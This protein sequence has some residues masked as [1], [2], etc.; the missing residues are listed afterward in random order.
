MLFRSAIPE[1]LT[2]AMTIVLSIA[3]SKMAKKK[4]IVKKLNAV[5]SLGSCS[6]IATDKT[7]T[8]TCNEQTAKKIILPTGD[9]AYIKGV[10]YNDLGEVEFDENM[11]NSSKEEIKEIAKLG[12]LNNEATLKFEDGKW[13][14][15][16]DAIDRA[17]LALAYKLQLKKEEEILETIPYES[18]D[19]KSV[20]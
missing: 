9:S 15:H 10:G 3:S 6:V 20:V 17:F 19:R 8:L 4:V 7:G 18:K 16:G 14:H 2:I 13:V 1:G 11:S 12:M 5:E